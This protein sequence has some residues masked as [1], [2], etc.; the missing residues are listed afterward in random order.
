MKGK[1][2]RKPLND[3]KEYKFVTLPNRIKTLL[4]C[5]EKAKFSG[6]CMRVNA[7]SHQFIFPSS[8]Y[9]YFIILSGKKVLFII[10]IIYCYYYVMTQILLK[11]SKTVRQR[12]S[13]ASLTS[14]VP[15]S[16]LSI[17]IS[18]LINNNK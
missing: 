2:I 6:A 14:A 11:I 1:E 13:P 10:I 15:S 18:I 4:V 17:F 9:Y 3:K 5:D 12:T 8:F 7:G 16:S